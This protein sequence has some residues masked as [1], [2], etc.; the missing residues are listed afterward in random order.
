MNSK[1]LSPKHVRLIMIVSALAV[2]ITAGLLVMRAMDDNLVFFVTPTDVVEKGDYED[3][4]FRLGGLVEEGSFKEDANGLTVT[5]RVTD[6]GASMPVT[7]SDLL[8]DLFREG[9]G[10]VAEGVWRGGTFYADTVLA[11]HDEKY[12]PPEVAE[13]LKRNGMW[14]DTANEPS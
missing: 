2:F 3:R 8:P 1:K 7:Y 5:F 14:K 6:G 12:M 4:R 9:Q 13:S 11:K 10:V